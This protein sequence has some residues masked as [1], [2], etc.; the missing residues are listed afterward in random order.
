MARQK[1][2]R[3]RANGEGSITR[4]RDGRYDCELPIYTPEG[5]K[6]LRTSIALNRRCR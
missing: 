4:R 2:G 6:R 3:T 1:K 5:T